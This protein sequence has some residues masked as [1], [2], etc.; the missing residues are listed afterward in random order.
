MNEYNFKRCFTC[1]AL[2]GGD[3]L[4]LVFALRGGGYYRDVGLRV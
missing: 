4:H 2:R 1:I 3:V